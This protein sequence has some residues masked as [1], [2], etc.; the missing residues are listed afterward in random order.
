MDKFKFDTFLSG[1]DSVMI[2]DA[3][4]NVLHA[5]RIGL[6]KKI[7]PG[8]SESHD[9]YIGK[10]LFDIYPTISPAESSYTEAMQTG[11]PSFR[12]NQRYE[13]CFGVV[14]YTNNLTIPLIDRGKIT[15]F[16]G[17]SKDITSIDHILTEEAL[18]SDE[19]SSIPRL[20][21][22]I[23]STTFDD[24]ITNNKEMEESIRL[25][26]KL[27]SF[28]NPILVYGET[29]TGKELIVQAIINYSNISRKKSLH[30]TVRQF[31]TI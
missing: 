8:S 22:C 9:I 14:Y 30:K 23:E 4:F 19:I 26:R 25:A 16:V 12:Y 20:K 27:V 6:H 17:L 11:Q 31:R 10:N 2:I 18:L 15:G 29:G 13:D 28:K 24:I 1:V 21:T 7:L 3:N 5:M